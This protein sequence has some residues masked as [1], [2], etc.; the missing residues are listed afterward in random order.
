MKH[1]VLSCFNGIIYR[2]RN[3]TCL[4][5]CS[6]ITMAYISFVYIGPNNRKHLLLSNKNC[7]DCANIGKQKNILSNFPSTSS[8]HTYVCR[9]LISTFFFPFVDTYVSHY[10][11][12]QSDCVSRFGSVEGTSIGTQS[13]KKLDAWTIFNVCQ[14]GKTGIVRKWNRESIARHVPR[15]I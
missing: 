11:I 5:N 10:I 1:F 15:L 3:I 2:I 8:I 6:R 7:Y 14:F 4:N 12:D 13:F 9:S